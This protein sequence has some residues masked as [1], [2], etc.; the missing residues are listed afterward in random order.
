M[1]TLS[2]FLPIDPLSGRVGLVLIMLV[3]LAA[4]RADGSDNGV[5]S[6]ITG[7]ICRGVI[8]AV[9]VVGWMADRVPSR[10]APLVAASAH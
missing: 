6:R 5:R 2:R 1:T 10:Q 4:D 3:A 7:L 9:G 8:E